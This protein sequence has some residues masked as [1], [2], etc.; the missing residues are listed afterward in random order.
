MKAAIAI[1]MAATI[2]GATARAWAYGEDVSEDEHSTAH[3][4]MALAMA[5]CSGF[6]NADATTIAEADE[7]VDTLAYGSTAFELASRTGR[8][9]WYFHFPEGV[10]SVD[11]NGDG[12]LRAWAEGTDTLIEGNGI[13]EE[14]DAEGTCCD[15]KGQCVTKGSL[16]SV[17]AWL[18]AVGD[19]WSHHACT[20]AGGT[21]H[22]DYEA[23]N[24]DQAA[25]CAP[26]MHNHEW[27][28][29][30]AT[31]YY[32]TLQANAIHGLQAMRDALAS[33]AAGIGRTA[34]GTISDTDLANFASQMTSALRMSTAHELYVA[35]DAACPAISDGDAGTGG[36]DDVP[37]GGGCTCA[38]PSHSL[39]MMLLVLG[40]LVR[41]RTGSRLSS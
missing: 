26:T 27:G 33:Y 32:A 13:A 4:D 35:C 16:E 8:L 31:G 17:G 38:T 10:G 18:H 29:R 30:E 19:Y 21:D 23:A 34:C 37:S 39:A 6:S 28:R 3:Y 2:T 12:P 25:Y 1:A 41:R 24:M 14:C 9:K 40:A 15:R 11:G 36:G 5:R 20:M 22:K 7:V